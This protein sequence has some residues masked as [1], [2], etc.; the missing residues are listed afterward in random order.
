MPTLAMGVRVKGGEQVRV[1]GSPPAQLHT[2]TCCSRTPDLGSRHVWPG[3]PAQLHTWLQPAC[4]LL[5]RY[6]IEAPFEALTTAVFNAPFALLMHDRFQE[7]VT[8]PRFIYANRAALSLFEAS[9]SELIGCPSRKSAA[10]EPSTQQVGGCSMGIGDPAG[11]MCM[12]SGNGA[13][14]TRGGGVFCC[15]TVCTPQ[16][17]AA[18]VMALSTMMAALVGKGKEEHAVCPCVRTLQERQQLLDQAATSGIITNYSGWRVSLKGKRFRITGVTLFNVEEPDGTKVGQA[19]LFTKYER[20]N[21]QEV[22]V[23]GYT[24]PSAQG[25][26]ASAQGPPSQE[27]LDA[28]QAAVLGWGNHI[29]GLK[30]QQGKGNKDPEVQAAVASLKAWKERQ[31]ALQ[32]RLDDEL[33][34]ARAAF[35]DDD[36]EEE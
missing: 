6:L 2:T 36:E 23:Q 12:S 28:A 17:P 29:R 1:R 4:C 25:G 3:E 27:E 10:D 33:A 24:D 26:D 11:N 13:G 8:D 31:A 19:A 20:E 35:D 14:Q 15:N 16:P 18:N 5:S 34:A 9:W 7:G 21:G 22:E 30:E 32:K